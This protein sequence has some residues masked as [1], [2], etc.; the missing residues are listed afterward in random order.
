MSVSFKDGRDIMKQAVGT[1]EA[2]PICLEIFWNILP[3]FLPLSAIL[4][5]WTFAAN[6]HTAEQAHLLRQTSLRLVTDIL[7]VIF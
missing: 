6:V 7:I 4:L 1:G 2:K 5:S 3:F